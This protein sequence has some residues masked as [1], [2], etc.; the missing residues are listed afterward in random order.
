[1]SSETTPQLNVIVH[2]LVLLSV[3]DHFH[4]VVGHHHVTMSSS[5]TDQ[6]R[7]KRVMG[8]LLGQVS[9]LEHQANVSNSYACKYSLRSP[10]GALFSDHLLI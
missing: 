6:Q 8:V 1:M 3:V 7:H 9:P 4:R 10:S 5:T 2:P